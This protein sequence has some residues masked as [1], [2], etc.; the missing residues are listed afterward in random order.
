MEA[1]T[2]TW[3]SHAE[4][5]S[6]LRRMVQMG[7]GLSKWFYDCTFTVVIITDVKKMGIYAPHLQFPTPNRPH[8]SQY[9]N[10]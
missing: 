6:Q 7:T 1:V 10:V 5:Y 2:I 3:T 8:T 9:W 4:W